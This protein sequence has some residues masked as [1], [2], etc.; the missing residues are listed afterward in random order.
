MSKLP[1]GVLTKAVEFAIGIK[2]ECVIRTAFDPNR[3]L[4]AFDKLGLALVLRIVVAEGAHL[5]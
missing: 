4:Y 1:I 5:A 2:D 3:I